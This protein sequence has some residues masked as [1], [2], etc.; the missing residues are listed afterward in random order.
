[1]FDGIQQANTKIA[2]NHGFGE[3]S[4]AFSFQ[5]K[6]EGFEA[7]NCFILIEK[8]YIHRNNCFMKI[9]LHFMIMSGN[10]NIND[11]F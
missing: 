3:N 1:M 2:I 8:F 5:M 9:H 11:T 10:L 4:I 7:L 6:G